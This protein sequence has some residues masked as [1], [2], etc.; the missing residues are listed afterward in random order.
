MSDAKHDHVPRTLPATGKTAGLTR[1]Q[2]VTVAGKALAGMA[3]LCGV[4][5]AARRRIGRRGEAPSPQTFQADRPGQE[6][7]AGKLRIATCQFPVGPNTAE[8]AKYVRDFMQARQQR[9]HT[10][11]THRRPACRDM[12]GAISRPSRSIRGTR[13]ARRRPTCAR[14]KELKLWLVL[15][16]AHFLDENTKPTNC[17]YL[18]DPAGKIVDRYDKCFCTGGDQRTTPSATAW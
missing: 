17:L 4:V 14:A 5:A 13:C 8:N 2:A 15:G 18:I 3:G 16:S 9:G 11:C 12:P 7:P 10:C 6:K 1:R